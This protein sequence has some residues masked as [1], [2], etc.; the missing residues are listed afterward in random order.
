MVLGTTNEQERQSVINTFQTIA[1]GIIVRDSDISLL[2]ALLTESGIA[3]AISSKRQDLVRLVGR[4]SQLNSHQAFFLLRHFSSIPKMT[5]I[6]RTTP[7]WR[8]MNELEEYDRQVRA[9]MEQVANCK[10]DTQVWK[11]CSLSVKFGGGIFEK[12]FLKLT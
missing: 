11:E 10:L 12:V 3:S 5:Y 7:C 8:A 1:P 2:G 9:A 6:L 4:L